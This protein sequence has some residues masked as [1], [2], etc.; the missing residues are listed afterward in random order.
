MCCKAKKKQNQIR[1]WATHFGSYISHLMFIFLSI[2]STSRQC[3][4]NRK[5]FP[6]VDSYSSKSSLWW[7]WFHFFN[8]ELNWIFVQFLQRCD[9]CNIVFTFATNKNRH[10]R[11]K[12]KTLI[13][14]KLCFLCF[15]VCST[16]SSF[17]VY[18]KREHGWLRKKRE[19]WFGNSNE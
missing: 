4:H 1:Y 19:I 17:N 9:I 7:T 13:K 6:N 3:I 16:S 5:T 11:L 18:S 12:H 2:I 15:R 8:C 14:K 10:N